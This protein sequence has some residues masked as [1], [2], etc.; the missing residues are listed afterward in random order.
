[1]VQ[2]RIEQLDDRIT[3]AQFAES[4][5]EEIIDLRCYRITIPKIREAFLSEKRKEREREET[6]LFTQGTTQEHKEADR[7]INQRFG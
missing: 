7:L 6:A 2:D 1:M 4:D 5:K 3:L